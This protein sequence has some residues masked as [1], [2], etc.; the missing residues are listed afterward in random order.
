MASV[1]RLFRAPRANAYSIEGLFSDIKSASSEHQIEDVFA[2]HPSTGLVSRLA[3]VAWA[4]RLNGDVLHVTGDVHYVALGLPKGKS[5]LTIHDQTLL[6]RLKGIRRFVAKTF[7]YYLPIRHVRY[8][9]VISEFTKQDLLRQVRVD[10]S[11]ICVIPNAIGREFTEAPMPRNSVPRLL[12][13]G[14]SLNKNID[15]VAEALTGVTCHLR[16]VG[17]PLEKDLI[18]LQKARI[19]Y[20]TVFGISKA[21]MVEEYQNADLVIFASTNEGFGL[22]ILEAQATARPVVTSNC[23]SMPEVA[24]DGAIFVD[25][26]NVSSIREGILR[27]LSDSVIR[28]ELVRAGLRNVA[29]F[30]LSRVAKQYEDLYSLCCNELPN[31]S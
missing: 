25:P 28:E 14:S 13:I 29:R 9:S 6:M 27:A 24:G 17:R 21:Q 16:I 12:Q 23:S 26:T 19:D 30:S 2:P 10:E 8:V 7:W 31:K 18:A 4:S 20:S 3:N 15:R 1:T 11:K 5:I 22:P